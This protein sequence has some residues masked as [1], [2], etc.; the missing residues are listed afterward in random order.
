MPE[1]ARM[2]IVDN[3]ID[4]DSYFIGAGDAFRISVADI[5]SQVYV[6]EV[7]Q[8]CNIFIP[9]LGLLVL[10]RASLSEAKEAIAT[11]V[12]QKLRKQNEVYVALERGKTATVTVTGTVANPGTYLL[13]GMARIL[14]AV[15]HANNGVLPPLTNFDSRNV[16]IGNGDSLRSID[17]LRYVLIDEVAQ[18]PYVYPGD[19][20]QVQRTTRQVFLNGEVRSV[21]GWI[22]IGEDERLEDFISMF[23]FSEAADSNSIVV[24][25]GPT[26]RDRTTRI[27]AWG[28]LGGI[29]LEDQDVV[30]VMRRQEYAEAHVVQI[31]GEVRRPGSYPIVRDQTSARDIVGL[32]DGETEDA[33]ME[34]SFIL[35]N[36]K[37]A[38]EQVRQSVSGSLVS[39]ALRPDLASVRPEISSGYY[40]M[41]SSSDYIVLRLEEQGMGTKVVAGD[42]II[43]PKK[44]GFVYLSGSVK[45]PG[46]YHYVRGKSYR[47]Y[48]K[49]AGGYTR[50]A[51]KANVC[52]LTQYGSVLQTKD[53]ASL[54]DGDII[55]VPDS[56]EH[57]FLRNVV[58]PVLQATATTIMAIVTVYS[59]MK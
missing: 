31:S 22:P 23:A 52:V 24:Q 47:H 6:A 53:V 16:Q 11:F 51:D 36:S 49:E 40:R 54:G 19:R 56:Q 8:N 48:I 21:S 4:P 30:T 37:M 50:K 1:N 27:L 32:A 29:R 7:D 33:D 2:G 55:M 20:I 35:R 41:F 34:R 5:A 13:S 25:K 17:L 3:S 57:K 38:S 46:A 39:G 58:L 26:I 59:L 43:V 10:G 9:E 42:H 18:N 15:K 12:R 14:D 45:R 28:E 44:D